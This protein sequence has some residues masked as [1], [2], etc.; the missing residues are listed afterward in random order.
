MVNNINSGN[1]NEIDLNSE[2]TIIR[3]SDFK[4]NNINNQ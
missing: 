2:E 4:D 3:N 1:I